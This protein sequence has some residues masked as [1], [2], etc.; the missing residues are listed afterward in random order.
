MEPRTEPRKEGN[1][2][3]EFWDVW[4]DEAAPASP[5]VASS[6]RETTTE[7]E[8]FADAGVGP[9]AD[10]ARLYINLGRKD[11]AGENEI[12]DL[13]RAHADFDD[14]RSIEVMNTHTY[15]NVPM[16]QADAIVQA[17]AGKTVGDRDIICEKAK[18]RRR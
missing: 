7:G 16:D 2:D 9:G 15:L 6:P 18:P 1:G 8:A 10:L 3:R 17:V 14:V 4:K 12:R 5:P 11:G 13:L